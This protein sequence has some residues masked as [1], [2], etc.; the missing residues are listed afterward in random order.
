MEDV[1]SAYPLIHNKV[2][3]PRFVTPTLRR[4]RL[5]NWLDEHSECRAMVI[6]AGAG[7][8]KTTLLWQ[9]EQTV[10][11]PCYWYKLDRN[12][13]DWTL[14]ISYLVE[15]VSQHYP[16][17]GRKA[18]S[19]LRQMGGP[20]SSRPGVTAFLLAEM[21]DRLK[22]PCTF[23]IDDWQ[24][25]ASVTEVRGLW[26]QILRDA[27]P[28][29]RFVF[30]SRGKPRL[31]FARFKTHG[32]YGELRT[33]ELRMTEPEITELFR[34]VYQDP[35]TADEAAELERRTEG[36]AASLQLVEVSLRERKTP[37]KRR[38]L[39][40]S[41]TARSDSDL[42]SF[43]AEEVL[44]QQT[45]ETRNFLLSTSI[46]QQITPDLA[47]RLA[48]AHDGMRRLLQLEHAGLFTYRLDEAR[49][50]YHGLFR[51]FLE[52]RLSEE[53]TDAEVT[54][55]HIHA[56]SYFETSTEWPE[57][58]Y[59]YL[60][61]GLQRQAARL[62]ARYGEDVVAEGRLG[63]VDEWLQQLPEKAIHDNA[64]LSLLHGEALGIRGEFES[65]L[66]ALERARTF[67]KRKG[68]RRMQALALVKE[69]SLYSHWGRPD[70][71]AEAARQALAVVPRDARDL[72]IRIR[73]NLTINQS[74]LQLPLAQ[75]QRELMRVIAEAM[76]MGLDH[77]AA[78][79]FHNLGQ[80]QLEMGELAHARKSLERAA[81]FWN[82][83]ASGP[84]ADNYNLVCCLLALGDFGRAKE[85]AIKGLAATRAWPRVHAEASCASARVYMAAGEFA[86]AVR[87]LEG[88][89][90]GR[91]DLG[92]STEM[93]L[94]HY[95]QAKLLDGDLDADAAE[96]ASRLGERNLDPRQAPDT[97]AILAAVS[98]E[99]GA[100]GDDCGR[101]ALAVALDWRDRGATLMASRA[102]LVGGHVAMSH[103]LP[104]AG[105]AVGRA[106]T[107]M[108]RLG[109]LRPNA[110]W[111]RRLAERTPP[112]YRLIDDEL[113]PELLGSDVHTW[114][115]QLLAGGLERITHPE[116]R[117][118][119]VA[120]LECRAGSAELGLLSAATAP[121]IAAVRYRL[122]IK[123][124]GRL[125]VRSFGKLSAR[126]GGWEG[127][128]IGVSKRRE[129]A[130]LSYLV[131][132]FGESISRDAILDAL[133]PETLLTAGV[134]SLNQTI[135]QLRRQIDPEYRDGVSPPYLLSTNESIEL[136]PD[137]VRVDWSELS[138][139]LSALHSESERREAARFALRVLRGQFLF[140][141]VY[142]DWASGPRQRIH[143]TIRSALL[144]VSTSEQIPPDIRV[145]IAESLVVLDEYDELA[146][147]S[148]ARALALS[149][150][151]VAGLRI[152][153]EL[154][155]RLHDESVGPSELVVAVMDELG[156]GGVQ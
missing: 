25:I 110:H 53:R 81:E 59:H 138:R 72:R 8:G 37:E 98:H 148:L 144:P 64:R 58:I 156:Q 66:A 116:S 41:I 16:G 152:I 135:F 127:P 141:S 13:R 14:H 131:A 17:F 9:W 133:W 146:H 95:L 91:P 145:R 112:L 105:P 103:R 129:R 130:L 93:V 11:F 46:L 78:I 155:S 39:I 121:D 28:T 87:A 43:L 99:Q 100:C 3:S 117:A 126:R 15:A 27:P 49:Y 26:N 101:D 153:R 36:W 6:A 23:I 120:A 32:G 5:L 42:F 20:G 67:F 45:E 119:A 123:H 82:Q 154:A 34:D 70:V 7:Y 71:G 2:I 30:A 79:G 84:F 114:S 118:A 106:I 92:A 33:N 48:G 74:W 19:I 107:D 52:R 150:R 143:H 21:H 122:T 136:N 31:Q 85:F 151:R 40:E 68:D 137:L 140:E 102:L 65:A 86:Q 89:V 113:W 104:G 47:E 147:V 22:E 12:D 108:V 149:G 61:A 94:C 38:A 51:D 96:I 44:E 139:R 88:H 4:P 50:R 10:D 132:H 24:Y 97:Q 62:I 60:R 111:I 124:A 90:F 57:A 54:G 125:F 134:N 63:M 75:T 128:S 1:K 115:R 142:D 80:L 109:T 29:C 77:Y 18:H 73:G 35:L 69:S 56:A 55:L 83:P 76:Q